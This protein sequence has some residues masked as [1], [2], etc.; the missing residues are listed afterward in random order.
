MGHQPGHGCPGGVLVTDFMEVTLTGVDGSQ[1][2]L[3]GP[4]IQ[5]SPVE[6]RPGFKKMIDAPA[7]TLWVQGANRMHY[8]GRQ[9]E[10]RD[11]I[12][13]V[14]IFGDDPDHWR[15]VDSKFRLALGLYDEEF[16]V[17][18]TTSDGT[19]HLD[20]RL[21]SDPIPYESGEWEKGKDPHLY[22]ASTLL[23][24][25][26]SAQPFWYADDWTKEFEVTSSTWSRT[27]DIENR[28]DIESWP[29]YFLAAPGTWTVDDKSFGQ[30][31]K[32]QRKAGVDVNR[33]APPFPALLV[34]EDLDVDADPD[35]ELMVADNEAPV[36]ARY[37]GN[38][39]LYPIPGGT[40]ATPWTISGTGLT[41]G[42]GAHMTL[43]RRFSR[44]LGVTV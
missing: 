2:Y 25:G 40:L 15:E 13:G 30:E 23:I 14:N 41:V 17:T 29:K 7:K 21:L 3:E 26:A 1:W 39:L 12:F 20:M 43:P 38:G 11:P 4:N 36:W 9:F 16:R 10:R 42:S 5:D 8:Q 34:G 27:F 22:S 32:R 24:N 28:G 35:E 18:V 44:P 37:N 6:L 19:R 31:W 33:T